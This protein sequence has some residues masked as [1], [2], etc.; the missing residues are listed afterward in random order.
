VKELSEEVVLDVRN[1]KKYFPVQEKGVIFNKPA[2]LIHACDDISFIVKRGKT[3]GLVGESGSGKTTLA[4]TILYLIPPTSG[5]VFF[6]GENLFKVFMSKNKREIQNLRRKMQYIFQDPYSSLN[7]RMT[8]SDI[9]IEPFQIHKHIPKKEWVSR[10]YEL[11]NYV[12]L[13]DYH[14]ERYPHEFSG[15]Q[16]QRICI[17]RALAVEPEF[18]IAD[19]PVSSLDVSIRAQILNLLR[20]LQS[21]LN[22]TYI[23]ISH[24]LSTIRHI[25]HQ[26]AVMYLGRI[27]ELAE[28][29]EIFD[30]PKHPYTKAL[31]SV[32]PTIE[33][34]IKI[35]RVIL[36]GEVASPINPPP[37]C[38]FYSRCKYH[39]PICEKNDPKLEEV[40]ANHF[41]ACFRAME[42]LE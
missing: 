15:G 37:Y 4:K 21:K 29:D 31:I 13:E 1:L 6:E 20:D 35:N 24:D 26:V 19:E 8:V 23:Y 12:G 40:S 11:L 32:I 18:L 17:A 33:E 2:G 5:E 27:V 39:I 9:I 10:M 36:P 14:A 38:R 16:R 28:V 41:A 42:K 22:L 25:C 34:N 3:L 30:S 7:P